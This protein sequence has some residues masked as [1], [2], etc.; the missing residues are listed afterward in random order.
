LVLDLDNT[1]VHSFSVIE[2]EKMRKD[3]RV[4]KTSLGFHLVARQ[5]LLQFLRYV[6]SFCNLYL[7]SFGAKQYVHDVVKLI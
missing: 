3:P 5:N 6:S 1:L 2:L 7:H 4:R